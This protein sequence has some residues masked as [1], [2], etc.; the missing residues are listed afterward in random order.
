MFIVVVL[1]KPLDFLQN[2]EYFFGHK[3]PEKPRRVWEM[4]WYYWFCETV[5]KE[6]FTELIENSIPSLSKLNEQLKH[7]IFA[8]I[9]KWEINIMKWLQNISRGIVPL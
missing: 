3:N 7:L 2:L 1:T 4:L 6:D 8:V 5:V 9:S